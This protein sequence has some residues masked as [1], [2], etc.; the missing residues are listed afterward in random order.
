[1]AHI[2]R[3]AGPQRSKKNL[4]LLCDCDSGNHEDDLAE[5]DDLENIEQVWKLVYAGYPHEDRDVLE[6][7]DLHLDVEYF[8]EECLDALGVVRDVV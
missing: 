1:V 7:D 8:C 6:H 3:L 2:Y 5:R 4:F